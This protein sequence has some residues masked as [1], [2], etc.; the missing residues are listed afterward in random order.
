MNFHALDI[1][2]IVVALICVRSWLAWR[3]RRA[4]SFPLP[5]GPR[6]L[7]IIGNVLD[8]PG[9][10]EWETARQWGE[11]Y[12]DLVYIENFGTRYLFV[13]S[14]EAAVE[15]FEKRGNMY[16]SRPS[17]TMINLEGFSDWFTG[18]MPYGDELKKSRQFLN[19]FFQKSVAKEYYDVQTQ[20]TH[21]L[22]SRL[23][24]SPDSFRDHIQH[25]AAETIVKIVYGYQIVEDDPYVA[26]VGRGM[27]A[28]SNA[29]TFYL[30]N[31][32]PA[33]RHLP[34]WFPGTT[35]HQIAE[36]GRKLSTAMYHE[37][38]D[39]TKAM[40]ADGTA[41]PS[42]TSKLLESHTDGDGNV[43]NEAL[44]AKAV[45]IAYAGGGDTTVSMLLTFLLAMVLYPDAMKKGQDELSRVIG[46]NNLPTFDDR[47]KLPYI[48]AIYY[49][50]LRWQTVAP[51]AN[52][53]LAEKDDIYNG[54]FIPAGTA[55]YPNSWAIL[56]DPKRYPEPEKFIPDRWLPSPG[57]ECPLDPN[58]V[59]FGF[60]RRIC[61]GRFFA[62]NSVFI[63][64]ASILA[65]FNIERALDENGVP[66]TP[67]EDYTSNIVRHPKPF[68]C[69]ITPRSEEAVAAI[70]QAAS[71]AK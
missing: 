12:G 55:V 58:K 45:G 69:K 8:M 62:E 60:G 34:A 48:E 71:F 7:P 31:A 68:K 14:Y 42:M 10:D 26:L 70:Y 18:V 21:N 63:G 32:L 23:L 2:A 1:T 61:P 65:V 6:G 67:I 52:I 24:Q 54:Y 30:V 11:K 59:A 15:L 37:P 39:K 9:K 13:N 4:N 53:H 50:C 36:E 57:K 56:R 25:T 27:E 46:K 35:F 3:K 41:E 29:L 66:I 22:L 47:P 28:F 33:L 38:F 49:E 64:I 16:S 44:I 17:V 5:P 43:L 40:I 19:M 51:V 20:S